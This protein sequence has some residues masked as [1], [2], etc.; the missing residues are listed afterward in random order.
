MAKPKVK[1]GKNA[2]MK[3]GKSTRGSSGKSKKLKIREMLK[4]LA[5]GYRERAWSMLSE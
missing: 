2:K 3:K 1:R 4:A 5:I